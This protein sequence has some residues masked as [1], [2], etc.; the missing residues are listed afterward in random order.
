MIRNFRWLIL[1][2]AAVATVVWACVA[3]VQ[4]QSGWMSPEISLAKGP[5]ILIDA[6]TFAMFCMVLAFGVAS[7][8]SSFGA[9]M[10]KAL[11][12]FAWSALPALAIALAAHF[13]GFHSQAWMAMAV[14]ALSAAGL[15][16]VYFN[17]RKNA[18]RKS[19]STAIRRSAT[20]SGQIKYCY[21]VL[22]ASLFLVVLAD[23][24]RFINACITDGAVEIYPDVAAVLLALVLWRVTKWRGILLPAIV[25]N[26]FTLLV[27]V[28][29]YAAVRM[30]DYSMAAANAI[31]SVVLCGELI[32]SLCELYCRKEGNV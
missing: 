6:M 32:V 19:S 11:K 22:Y 13:A 18:G 16:A 23:L 7:G 2:L 25:C 31:S 26:L 30:P 24:G 5:A 17:G 20:G 4:P 10:G 9:M 1:A 27:T 14:A 28:H 8:R 15:V 21:S 29:N 12:I 3:V